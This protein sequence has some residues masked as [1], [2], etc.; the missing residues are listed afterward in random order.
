MPLVGQLPGAVIATGLQEPRKV[1]VDSVPERLVEKAVRAIDENQ[2]LRPLALPFGTFSLDDTLDGS[3]CQLSQWAYVRR[4]RQLGELHKAVQFVHLDI[5][6]SL[7][8]QVGDGTFGK[9][10]K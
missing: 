2:G 1:V 4:R 8:F 6:I 3:H 10:L 5:R 9:R 7:G